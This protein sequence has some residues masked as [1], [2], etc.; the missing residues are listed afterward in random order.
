MLTLVLEILEVLLLLNI[1][2]VILFLILSFNLS[3]N[4]LRLSA[5]GLGGSLGDL[6]GIAV[7]A[8]TDGL[9]ARLD[10]GWCSDGA[11]F[12]VADLLLNLAKSGTSTDAVGIASSLSDELPV[13]LRKASY[14]L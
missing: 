13:N 2:V 4:G 12:L 10:W 5:T 9:L 11:I 7:G 3:L 14:N 1:L 6:G 8:T